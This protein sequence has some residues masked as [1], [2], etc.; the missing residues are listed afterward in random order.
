MTQE[1]I[2]ISE[3]NPASYN[4]RKITKRGMERLVAS[5]RE[6]TAAL[7]DWDE[8][9]GYRLASTITVNVRGNRIVGG[10]QRIAAIVSLG[11]S[12]VHPDDI[13]WVDVEPDSAEEKSLNISLNESSGDWDV[14][15]LDTML[16]S[17]EESSK[18]LFDAL[19]FSTI[20][21]DT[22]KTV[23]KSV[24]SADVKDHLD[25]IVREVLEKHGTSVQN[26]F[27]YFCYK[28]RL[29]LVV[30]CNK[31]VYGLLKQLTEGLQRNNILINDYLE[32]VILDSFDTVKW[33]V[34]R[35]V[36]EELYND[37]EDGN[38]GSSGGC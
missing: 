13:T 29:H 15:A 19:S 11:Q 38:L 27:I 7:A 17:I 1:R 32:S 35:H 20:V 31:V 37:G 23:S 8:S 21:E 34:L 5:V 33:H 6:H 18:D 22:V 16:H 9:D 25:F 30:L 3:L 10:H 24:V 2:S 26:G 36:A 28:N 12:W 4:P 14:E